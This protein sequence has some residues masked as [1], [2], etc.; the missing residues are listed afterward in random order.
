MQIPGLFGAAAGM[1]LGLAFLRR[2]SLLGIVAAVLAGLAFAILASAG[3]AIIPRYTMLASAVLCVFCALALLGWRLLPADH[4]WRRRWQ[5]IAA[6]T[7]ILFVAQLPQQLDYLETVRTDLDEQSAVESDLHD[8]ADS[9]SF[10]EDCVP[11][12]VPNHR[13]VPRLAAWLDVTPS[14]IVSSSQQRQPSRGYFL[15]P[16]SEEVVRNFVLDPNDPARYEEP[17]PPGFRAVRIENDSWRL[18]SRCR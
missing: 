13:A 5:A 15:E 4:S 3:L 17:A 7:A 14:D 11:I 1:V 2:R 12:S 18:Y 10:R 16:V 6:L 8:L 9:G